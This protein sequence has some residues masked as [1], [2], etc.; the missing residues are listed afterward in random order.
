MNADG[1]KKSHG[2]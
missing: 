1:I 2:P